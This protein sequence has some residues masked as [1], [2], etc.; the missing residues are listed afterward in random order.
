[1]A[2]TAGSGVSST[3]AGLPVLLDLGCGAGLLAD[4]LDGA[5]QLDD[6]EYRGIDLSEEMIGS[7]RSRWPNLHFDC[8][9]VLSDPLP[10]LSVDYVVMNGVLTEKREIDQQTMTQFAEKLIVQAFSFARVGLAFNVMS[11]HVDWE[12]SD[13]F[14]WSFDEVATFL[15]RDVTRRFVFRAD[16]GLYEY[17]VYLYRQATAEE[18]SSP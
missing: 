4:F 15:T 6:L 14:H 17:S 10:E 13:L 9:D 1:M 2:M 12:R 3:D 16:Y 7:A 5:G 8:R 11:K 18:A